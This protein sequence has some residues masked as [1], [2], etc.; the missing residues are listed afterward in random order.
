MPEVTPRGGQIR[1]TLGFP[2]VADGLSVSV[3]IISHNYG[4][5]LK[6]A[7]VSVRNQLHRDTEIVVIDDDSDDET[8]QVALEQKVDYW[9]V[10]YRNV[11]HVR[12]FAVDH[13]VGEIVCFLDADDAIPPNYIRD[14]LGYFSDHRVGIVYSDMMTFGEGDTGETLCFPEVFDSSRLQ[15]DNFMHAGSLVR[16][17]AI[18]SSQT[19]EHGI[20]DGC[21]VADWTVWRRIIAQGWKA[22]KQTALYLYRQHDTNATSKIEEEGHS[23]YLKANLELEPITLFIPLSGREHLWSRMSKFLDRQTW[24]KRQTRLVL[25]DTSGEL[26]FHYRVK[27]WVRDCGYHDTRV[28]WWDAGEPQGIADADRLDDDNCRSVRRAVA[29]IYNKM[30][31]ELNTEYVWIVEDDVLPPDDACEVLMKAFEPNVVSVAGVV[32]SR[33]SSSYLHWEKDGTIVTVPPLPESETV[34]AGG[35]NGFGCTILRK[36]CLKDEVFRCDPAFMSGDYDVSFYKRLKGE[37][38]VHWGVRCQHG[39]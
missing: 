1:S 16:R 9:K 17:E 2:A 32:Q 31:R 22:R 33:L 35:G 4:K 7:I 38:L 21:L 28:I 5:Y 24:P 14:G 25:L 6:D 23:Y 39:V 11:F 13:T 27:D 3:A 15:E 34:I 18:L 19:F 12:Q 10:H 37:A 29:R 36:S 30:A 26:G 20:M 8:K